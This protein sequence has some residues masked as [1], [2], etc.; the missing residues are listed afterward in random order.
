M[1]VI[2]HQLTKG[3]DEKSKDLSAGSHLPSAMT[4]TCQ[5]EAK[6]EHSTR[7]CKDFL[8]SKSSVM[9]VWAVKDA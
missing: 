7:V 2:S 4:P 9:A 5:K 3:T 1:S 8:V 6:S